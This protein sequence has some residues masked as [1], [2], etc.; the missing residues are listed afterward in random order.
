MAGALAWKGYEWQ[1]MTT[2]APRAAAG[3][4]HALP[5]GVVCSLQTTLDP[6]PGLS[7][8]PGSRQA[9]TFP[10]QPL[11][12]SPPP[13]QAHEEGRTTAIPEPEGNPAPEA[14]SET[15]GSSKARG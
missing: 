12:C 8:Q 4:S 13:P 7:R 10:L 3:G 15:V 5:P 14:T 6:W 2:E 1:D 11:T 9:E